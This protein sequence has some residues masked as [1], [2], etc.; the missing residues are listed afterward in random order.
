[1]IFTGMFFIWIA[2]QCMFNWIPWGWVPSVVKTLW[3]GT[4]WTFGWIPWI[5]IIG[6][7]IYKIIHRIRRKTWK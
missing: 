6:F 7:A 4:T 1:M 3:T 5:M 2:Y